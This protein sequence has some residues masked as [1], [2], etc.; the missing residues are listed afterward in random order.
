VLSIVKT[1]TLVPANLGLVCSIKVVDLSNEYMLSNEGRLN[2][3]AFFPILSDTVDTKV[4]KS[5]MRMAVYTHCSPTACTY[6]AIIWPF[7]FSEY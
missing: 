2:Y 4:P 3:H 1:C 6:N 7:E 5:Q